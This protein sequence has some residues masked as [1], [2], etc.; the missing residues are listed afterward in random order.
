MQVLRKLLERHWQNVKWILR[1]YNIPNP[2]K[3]GVTFVFRFKPRKSFIYNCPTSPDK[4]WFKAALPSSDT[5][6]FL[7][8]EKK[9]L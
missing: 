7:H 8:W 5:T 1:L 6:E 4:Y 3:W 2:E 9:R